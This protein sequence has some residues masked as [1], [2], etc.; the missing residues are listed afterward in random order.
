MSNRHLYR[1]TAT[2]FTNVDP[3]RLGLGD[4]ARA[5]ETGDGGFVTGRTTDVIR[6]ATLL[7]DP[8]INQDVLDFFGITPESA[9]PPLCQIGNCHDDPEHAEEAAALL[10]TYDENGGICA[11]DLVCE[12]HGEGW[13]DDTPET[14]RIRYDLRLNRR[15]GTSHLA[16][17]P[18]RQH[19]PG[20]TSSRGAQHARSSPAPLF[21][22]PSRRSTIMNIYQALASCEPTILKPGEEFGVDT[23]GDDEFGVQLDE[24]VIYGPPST[25]HKYAQ[26]I[27]D[28][29]PT[30]TNGTLPERTQRAV[31]VAE[32]FFWAVV[33]A[34]FP[35]VTTGDPNPV[36]AFALNQEMEGTVA[37][38]LRHNH[39]AHQNARKH[40]IKP[41]VS[42]AAVQS[43]ADAPYPGAV[44]VND[45]DGASS[46]SDRW[47]VLPADDA[48]SA[49][50]TVVAAA[51]ALV[52]AF[53]TPLDDDRRAAASARA[54]NE[55][56]CPR[57]FT[58]PLT[59]TGFC[60][61]C[62]DVRCGFGDG[63]L[64]GLPLP[65]DIDA[66]ARF[67]TAHMGSCQ[68]NP[69]ECLLCAFPTRACPE[70]D[71]SVGAPG[72]DDGDHRLVNAYVGVGCEGYVLP[73]LRAAGVLASLKAAPATQPWPIGIHE[74][75]CWIDGE[76]F[77][78]YGPDDLIH[79]ARTNG[80][81]CDGRGRYV[82]T[83]RR[84]EV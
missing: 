66:A 42:S 70:C 81:P 17:D 23:L 19:Q 83:A 43:L 9:R 71:R 2:I 50:Y 15:E 77:N 64:V 12:V 76:T 52:A 5:V 13:F 3:E 30:P 79:R 18:P 74:A 28:A 38:W 82:G 54:I 46:G 29:V 4:V 72:W 80:E 58:D 65:T 1:T 62:A 75:V 8:D 24:M 60:G 32:A 31:E 53:G 68:L 63:D 20:P 14:W 41:D 45:V 7:C 67:A 35:E 22:S 39:P 37:A 27:V 49:G 48:T 56:R 84:R 26:A 6:Y 11:W 55:G 21:P 34:H 25:L 78:P 47:L 59:R 16:E 44:L 40:A 10:P 69:R 57:C 51:E 33:G 73:L 61:D 36:K